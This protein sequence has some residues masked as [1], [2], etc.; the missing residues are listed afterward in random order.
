MADAVDWSYVSC[1]AVSR[2]AKVS[3]VIG[4][5][6]ISVWKRILGLI[7][8]G[9]TVLIAIPTIVG[10]EVLGEDQKRWLLN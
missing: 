3:T 1:F 5:V 2:V 6:D 8:G 9:A 10:G 7:V 4:N